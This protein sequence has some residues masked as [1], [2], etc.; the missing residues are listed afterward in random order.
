MPWGLAGYNFL[1]SKRGKQKLPFAYTLDLYMEGK[2]YSLVNGAHLQKALFLPWF[3]IHVKF[4]SKTH[5]PVN[6]FFFFFCLIC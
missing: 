4:H 6:F 1:P 3:Q 5:T 2:L